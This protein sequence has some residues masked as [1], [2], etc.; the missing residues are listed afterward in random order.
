ML[1][2]RVDSMRDLSMEL[3][4]CKLQVDHSAVRLTVHVINRLSMM[5]ISLHN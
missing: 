1:S 3:V 5:M 2:K 4:T